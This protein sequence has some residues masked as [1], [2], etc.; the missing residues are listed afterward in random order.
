MTDENA[1]T[2]D[3]TIDEK[4]DQILRKL[5]DLDARLGALESQGTNT[6][7][8]LLDQIIKEMVTM[9][10]TLTERI[11]ALEKHLRGLDR[12]F[13]IFAE[14]IGRMRADIRDFDERLTDLERRPN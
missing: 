12:R 4:L 6:T 2:A 8:P 14:D 5:G 1:N 10:E 11:G 3:L 9:R 13:A 7:R